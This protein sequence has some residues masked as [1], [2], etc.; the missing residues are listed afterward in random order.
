MTNYHFLQLKSHCVKWFIICLIQSKYAIFNAFQCVTMFC[1]LSNKTSD[2]LNSWKPL[3]LRVYSVT[4]WLAIIWSFKTMKI[5][6]KQKY[7]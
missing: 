5:I 1:S 4:R 2:F 3:S 7:Y 6:Q